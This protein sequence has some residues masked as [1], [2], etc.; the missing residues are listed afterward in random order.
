MQISS[1]VEIVLF[2]DAFSLCNFMITET[3]CIVANDRR[4]PVK[5]KSCWYKVQEIYGWVVLTK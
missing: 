4:Y 2:R 1:E 5:S 3:V